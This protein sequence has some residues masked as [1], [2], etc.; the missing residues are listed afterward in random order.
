MVATTLVTIDG[1]LTIVARLA[2]LAQAALAAG[3]TSVPAADVQAILDDAVRVRDETLAQL[4]QD[5]ADARAQ[6]QIS[7]GGLQD[8]QSLAKP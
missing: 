3:Q 7:A 2:P 1:I 5:I 4:D 8:P 6:Q